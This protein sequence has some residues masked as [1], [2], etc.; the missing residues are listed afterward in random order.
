MPSSTQRRRAANRARTTLP[1]RRRPTANQRRAR[2]G[3]VVLGIAISLALVFALVAT[4]TSTSTGTPAATTP[5]QTDPNQLIAR[6]TANPNDA[7]AAGALADYYYTTGQ[8]QQ[9]LIAYQRYLLLRPDDARAHVSI[10]VLLLN[11]GDVPDAQNQF[12]Q[13]L[14]LKPAADTAAQAH[15]GLG[16]AYTA[17]QP[18]RLTDALN[19]YRQASDLDPAGT[20]G[21]E[22]RSRSAAIQQ[23]IGSGTVT[24]VAPTTGPAGSSVVPTVG[25]TGTP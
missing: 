5:S 12:A 25:P 8:Y 3:L 2:R 10:G 7:D 19:E 16:N 15:L 14:A 1:Q 11:S 17:L 4:F 22:A 24:V 9:A 20:A 6:A 13:A 21:D 18:P 23:Q